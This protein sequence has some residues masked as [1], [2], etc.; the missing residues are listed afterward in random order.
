MG[1]NLYQMTPQNVAPIFPATNAIFSFF[2]LRENPFN[3]N[4]N[5]RF[6]Y[7]TP[8]AQAA[9]QQLVDAICDRK[10]LILLTGE[11]GTG[12]TLLLRRLLDW[13]AEQKMPTALI[14]N[15]HIHPE[16]LLDFIL[17][18]FGI[19][20]NSSLKSDKLISLSRWLLDRYRL[21]QTPVLIV[22]EAQGLPLRTLEEIRL[23]LNLETSC[24]KLLQVILAG[25]PELE[26]KLK[27]HE[28][29]Q[30][31]QRV[32][33][34][35]RTAP[36]AQQ[37]TQAYI[38]ERLRIAG[39]RQLIFQRQA[40]I[41]IHAYARGIPRVVNV[42]CEHALINA[43]ADGSRVV[44]PQ[45]VECAA[46]DCQ[47]DGIDLIKRALNS[48]DPV[49]L[50]LGDFSSIFAETPRFA[51]APPPGACS[52]GSSVL[53]QALSMAVDSEVQVRMMLSGP[54]QAGTNPDAPN[55]DA[56]SPMVLQET[57]SEAGPVAVVRTE[58]PTVVFPPLREQDA[59]QS[60]RDSLNAVH[61]QAS[62]PAIRAD[63]LQLCATV[64]RATISLLQ[65]WRRSFSADARSTW[66][67][68][69]RF[70]TA[71]TLRVRPCARGRT[72]C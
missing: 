19:S 11:V 7:L 37:E 25:Q 8:L 22:D 24:A 30:F 16:H 34:R 17:S 31:R 55:P 9:S 13:L 18:D 62:E 26:E 42:L 58:N 38:H 15:S 36:L 66:R 65:G 41:S 33:V 27:R 40:A 49:E 4:P 70:V 48:S 47:I 5:P 46:R 51:A 64:S 69:R 71:Q 57:D 56:R 53:A 1:I 44:T 54:R 10:G 12:K 39:A 29:R 63:I 72:N 67:Q 23:L 60:K 20:C 59:T 21:G 50:G 14:F 68:L 52:S 45:Y 32:T 35:C 6:L 28:L 43:Y 61:T 3:I 2:G